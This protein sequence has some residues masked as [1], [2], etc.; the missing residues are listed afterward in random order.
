MRLAWRRAI[1][2]ELGELG[3][4]QPWVADEAGVVDPRGEHLP[5]SAAVRN[6]RFQVVGRNT[7]LRPPVDWLQDP[8]DSRSWRYQLHTLAWLRPTIERHAIGGDPDALAAA[9]DVV[10]D[11][12]RQHVGEGGQAGEGV[13]AQVSEF[14][15]YDM[16]VGL[17]AP[18]IA[19]VLRAGLHEGRLDGDDASLLVAAAERHGDALADPDNYAAGHNHGLY[20]DEGLYLLARQLPALPLAE[21][22]AELARGRMRSTLRSTV[23]FD[24]GAHLEHSTAYQFAIVNLV[25]RL[26]ANVD[27]VPELDE[28][29]G[30]L[31]RTAAWHVTPAGRLVQLGDTDDIEAPA[32]ARDAASHLRGLN[33]LFDAGQ[34][35]VRD[36]NSYLAVTAAHHGSG[37]KQADDAG[38][39]LV[40]GGR[41]L[42]GDAGRWGYYEREPDRLY[43]R[44]NRAHNV[45]VVDDEDLDWRHADPYGSGLLA[46]GEGDGWY[47][48]LVSNRLLAAKG[49]AH[50]RL[51][52]YRPGDRLIVVDDVR[53][54]EPHEYAR[55]FHFGPHLDAEMV[56]GRIRVSGDA[57]Q[58][59]ASATLFDATAGLSIALA[60]G[61]DHPD[62]LGWTYPADRR[63]TPVWTAVLRADAR[64]A[65]FV[66]TLSLGDD[67]PSAVTATLT[68]T[69]ATL[70]ADDRP[71]ATVAFDGRRAEVAGSQ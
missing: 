56:D 44:S 55:H 6:R 63:R 64:D 2:D 67:P 8:H 62:R 59:P 21:G 68:A 9:C 10:V 20:Q 66:A 54:D 15:W 18:Y 24:E 42:L 34:A 25:S 29:L 39:A 13:D 52:L 60:R 65:T 35:F 16:A 22:W 41:V 19:Y 71:L 30:R 31:R 38:F 37:H 36:G 70:H 4:P 43:A 27:G 11:W 47:A 23:S 5:E 46:A 32:W 51:L 69:A 12:A 1:V 45:L 53:A 49:V 48:I 57:A 28:L 50:R 14:A 3:P 7:K 26:A 61:R 58:L 17:R 40:E 33:A